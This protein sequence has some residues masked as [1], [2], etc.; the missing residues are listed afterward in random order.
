[1]YSEKLTTTLTRA[2]EL[3]TSLTENQQ[4]KT[5]LKELEDKNKELE[6]LISVHKSEKAKSTK[7]VLMLNKAVTRLTSKLNTQ[8]EE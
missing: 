5:Q 3:Q 2:S 8:T 7:E 4:L 1:M 6:K